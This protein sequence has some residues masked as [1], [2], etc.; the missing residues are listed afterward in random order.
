MRCLVTGTAGFIGFHLARRLLAD[1]H[2]VTGIDGMTPYYDVRLKERRYAVLTGTAGFAAHR[3]M[4][5]DADLIE[6][7]AAR[8]APD[9]VIHLAA[10]AGVRYSLENPR[11]Y[12]D[13]NLVGTFTILELCRALKPR[14]VLIASTSSIY[15]ANTAL[16][17]AETDAADHPLTLYAASK[18]SV[19]LMAHSYAHLWHLPTTIFRFFTVYGPW[20]RPDMALFKFVDNILAGR[21]IEIYNFGQMERDFT[22]I[23]DLVEAIVSLIDRV[24]VRGRKIGPEDSLSPVAPFRIVN[25]GGGH[26]I[27]L[28]AFIEAVEAAL[29][30]R[31]ERRYREAQPGDVPKTAASTKLLEALI[32]HRP[33]TPLAVGVAEFVRW[34]RD[35]YGLPAA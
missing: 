22:Y 33:R 8:A 20:G 26:P 1:G 2:Q 32:G 12:V 35:Y 16:P 18:K 17:F 5:E 11:A 15:G 27:S 4:L 31:A 34:Y 23:D 28:L 21:P 19:E 9:I 13:A 14:H 24:P 3:A 7:I 10:Q 6:R 29:G 25:I 30:R